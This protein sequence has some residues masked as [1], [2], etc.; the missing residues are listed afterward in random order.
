MRKRMKNALT[1]VDEFLEDWCE[2][3][4]QHFN[5]PFTASGL[6][7]GLSLTK[8]EAQRVIRH[9]ASRGKIKKVWRVGRNAHQKAQLWVK[10]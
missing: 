3:A 7:M 2:R 5:K 6:A 4:I 9:L 1:E 8:T 10:T